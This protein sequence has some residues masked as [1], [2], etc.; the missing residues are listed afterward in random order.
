MTG[1]DQSTDSEADVQDGWGVARVRIP[2]R[3]DI[4]DCTRTGLQRWDSTIG[5][6]E[7]ESTLGST[8]ASSISKPIANPA[9]LPRPISV[10]RASRKERTARRTTI[11]ES[12]T[13]RPSGLGQ[14]IHLAPQFGQFPGKF[15]HRIRGKLTSVWHSLHRKVTAQIFSRSKVVWDV[16]VVMTFPFSVCSPCTGSQ[17][18]ALRTTGR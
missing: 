1:A 13:R 5:V 4:S 3:I 17:C 14:L 15:A 6:G 10:W 2:T 12:S 8:L 11:G 16:F 7:S 18:A 9:S